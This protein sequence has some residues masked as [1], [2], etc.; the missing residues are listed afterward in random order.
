MRVNDSAMRSAFVVKPQ[1][2]GGVG[3]ENSALGGS[4]VELP[5]IRRSDQSG[6]R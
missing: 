6:I 1:V 5:F 4:E 3:H 2:I